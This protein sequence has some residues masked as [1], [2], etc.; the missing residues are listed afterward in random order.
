[1]QLIT[2]HEK[3]MKS[4]VLFTEACVAQLDQGKERAQT[5]K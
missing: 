1:M 5:P 3:E 2:E 4:F